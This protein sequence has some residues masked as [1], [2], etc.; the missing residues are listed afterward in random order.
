MYGNSLSKQ[1]VGQ[2]LVKQQAGASP[3]TGMSF[4]NL[5]Q[6]FEP[7][8]SYIKTAYR[9]YLLLNPE[10][11]MG[12]C[13][14]KYLYMNFP[15]MRFFRM[16]NL[17]FI[18]RRAYVMMTK[19][20]NNLLSGNIFAPPEPQT[21]IDRVGFKVASITKERPKPKTPQL[22]TINSG[23]YSLPQ[24]RKNYYYLPSNVAYQ[25][26]TVTPNLVY[27]RVKRQTAQLPSNQQYTPEEQSV[28]S[29][30]AQPK[31][32]HPTEF[33]DNVQDFENMDADAKIDLSNPSL[34]YEADQLFNLDSMFWK[35]MGVEDNSIKKYSL[36]YCGRE[37][38]SDILKRFVKNVILS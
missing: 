15:I 11:K 16:S 10:I 22:N 30:Q 6:Y 31:K 7:I 3:P 34:L 12:Q 28:K 8:R 25:P 27:Q 37:Y 13:L 14:Y 35:S 21:D 2:S 1:E 19:F 9:T 23:L 5:Q 26:M 17:Q 38:T 24:S 4:P 18:A 29:Q 32:E 33:T 36:A 20:F